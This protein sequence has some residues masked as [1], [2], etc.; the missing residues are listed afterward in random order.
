MIVGL[1]DSEGSR[2]N[3]AIRALRHA[4]YQGR[5]YITE[6]CRAAAL[7]GYVMGLTSALV[8]K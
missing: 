5:G 8:R 7:T 1:L 6:F 4:R 2:W 3:P